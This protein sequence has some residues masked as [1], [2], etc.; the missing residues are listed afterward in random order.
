MGNARVF[1]RKAIPVRGHTRGSSYVRPYVRSSDNPE[2]RE[3]PSV[4]VLSTTFASGE[5]QDLPDRIAV[6]GKTYRIRGAPNRPLD[7][8]FDEKASMVAEYYPIASN[9]DTTGKLVFY[10]VPRGLAILPYCVRL[11]TRHY[12][13]HAH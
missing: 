9:Q 6:A 5:L 12:V 7:E 1:F 13:P 4:E 3:F 10:W 2:T 8:V 11:K